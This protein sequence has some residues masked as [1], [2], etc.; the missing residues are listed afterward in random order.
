MA[1]IPGFSRWLGLCVLLVTLTFGPPRLCG[2]AWVQPAGH[3]QVIVNLS[4][5]NISEGFDESGK[6]RPFG[7][8]G[9]FR[10]LELNPY[11]EFGLS[12][13][14]TL[15]V[16][17]FLPALKYSNRYGV[18]N[19]FGL[20]NV[21]TG[22]R[23]RL[24]S[25][26][27]RTAVSAQVTIQFPAYTVARDP[28]PGN[29]QLDV[30]GRLLVGQGFEVGRRHSFVSGAAAHRYRNGPPADQFRSDAA[31]GLDIHRRLMVLAQYSGITGLRNGSPITVTTNPNL[32][33]DFDL[34][35]G[36]VSLVARVGRRTRVQFG[37]V[38][39][40]AGRNTGRG[41]SVQAAIWKE[42]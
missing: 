7:D 39:V 8:S 36:Q 37:W 29:H 18:H 38:D 23:R 30:E 20:G 13:R 19:S 22:V 24:N 3:G 42:F 41:N 12:T 25:P 10:K 40:F 16:N 6:A 1:S 5:M 9:K 31:W 4:H 34:Y 14:T 33:S 21:E 15:V 35:K 26:D 17:M 2:D 32:Q 27:S 11:F 28:L